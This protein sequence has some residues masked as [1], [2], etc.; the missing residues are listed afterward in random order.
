[1]FNFYLSIVLGSNLSDARRVRS[2]TEDLVKDDASTSSYNH[3]EAHINPCLLISPSC[4]ENEEVEDNHHHHL[5][6]EEED[7]EI[8]DEHHH[9]VK[10]QVGVIHSFLH[11]YM[12]FLHS[13]LLENVCMK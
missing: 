8:E 6:C 13:R 2:D 7:D 12:Y 9:A 11:L 5:D 10:F 4:S 1:M 3:H